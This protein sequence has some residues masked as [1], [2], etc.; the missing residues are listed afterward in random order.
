MAAERC[1]GSVELGRA[2]CRELSL[3]RCPIERRPGVRLAAGRDGAVADDVG[4]AQGAKGAAQR[5]NEL[6]ERA[7]L[8]RGVRQVVRAF[9]LDSDREI[10][11]RGASAILGRPG[12]P[13]SPVE[14]HVW[15]EPAIARE[16]HV[17]GHHR[18]LE[19]CEERVGIDGQIDGHL[20]PRNLLKCSAGMRAKL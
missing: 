15:R 6:A 8:R 18:A 1:S 14:R 12:V 10:V 7:V 5:R 20:R 17:L 13:R 19:G 2:R 16:Q 11:A 4:V 9:E 3:E